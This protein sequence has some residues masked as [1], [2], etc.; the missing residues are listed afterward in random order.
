MKVRA[1]KAM[2]FAL[3]AV[4]GS[5]AG[6]AP[7]HDPHEVGEAE[8]SLLARALPKAQGTLTF[9]ARDGARRERRP[10]DDRLDENEALALRHPELD[11]KSHFLLRGKTLRFSFNQPLRGAKAGEPAARHIAVTPPITGVAVG[12]DDRTLELEAARYLDPKTKFSVTL[13]NIESVSGHKLAP[14]EATFRSTVGALI[15]GKE[16]GHVPVRGQPR[17]VAIVPGDATLG[18]RPTLRVLYDQPIAL[19]RARTLVRLEDEDDTSVPLA[20]AHAPENVFEGSR[21]DRHF[22]VVAVP[23]KALERGEDYVFSADDD[24]PDPQRHPNGF[25]VA[26]R[27]AL[28]G[29]ACGWSDDDARCQRDVA[30]RKVKTSEQEVHLVFNN[31]LRTPRHGLVPHVRVTPPV[32]NLA[33]SEVG[34]DEGRLQVT[35]DF[36]PSTRYRIS[37]SGLV[38]VF[39]QRQTDAVQVDL[40]IDALGASISMAEGLIMLDAARTRAFTI[41]SRN[42]A[43]A[44]LRLWKLKEGDVAAFKQG[45]AT[46]NGQNAKD[47]APDRKVRVAVVPRRDDIVTT[48]VD[49]RH[50]LGQGTSYL[51]T[52]VPTRFAFGAGPVGDGDGTTRPPVAL[53]RLAHDKSLRAHVHRSEGKTIV[54][55]AHLA[56]GMPVKDARVRLAK[57]SAK[58]ARKSDA[59]GIVTLPSD[60]VESDDMLVVEAPGDKLLLPLSQRHANAEALFPELARGESVSLNM[61]G[62]VVTD[63]G[64]YRPGSPVEIK[65][66]LFENQEGRLVP[67]AGRAVR[68]K[69]M[70]PTDHEV[71]G[72]SHKTSASGGVATRCA[73]PP[74]A[75]LGLY[76][77]EVESDDRTVASGVVRVA[78]FEAPRFKV[79]VEAGVAKQQLSSTV[80]AQ[81]LF[82]SPLEGA[83]VD[84]TLKRSPATLPAG[85]LAEL[86]LS[87]TSEP[88]WWDAEDDSDA[89]TQSGS[90]LL[91]AK[92]TVTLKQAVTMAGTRGPQRFTL[93]ADVSDSSYRHVANR[94]SVV[95]HTAKRYAG[96]RLP[97]SWVPLDQPIKVEL[98]VVDHDGKSVSGAATMAR[99]LAVD[100]REQRVRVA[101]GAVRSEWRRTEVEVARCT[102]TSGTRPV[103]C[104]LEPPRSGDYRVTAEVDGKV[105]GSSDVYAWDGED[106]THEARHPNRG[107]AIPLA[108][109][110]ASYAP[111]D[112]ARILVRNPYPAAIAILT[113]EQGELL[114]YESKRIDASAAVFEVPVTASHAPHLHASVTLLPIGAVD[115]EAV[116]YRIGALRLPVT[117]KGSR[118]DVAVTS[119]EP[120]YRPGAEADLELTVR[121]G[122]RPEA[123]AEVALAVVDEGV[124]RLT[125]FHALDPTSTLRPPLALDFEVSSSH[126]SLAE[127]LERSHVAGDGGG[128]EQS[129]TDARRRFVETAL[130]QPSVRTDAD[131]RARIRFRLPD[132]LTEFRIMAVAVDGEGKGGSAEGSFV[133]NKPLMIDPV[134]PRFAHRGDRLELAAMVHNQSASPFRG[135]VRIG[136]TTLPVSVEPGAR[137]RV[138]VETTLDEPGVR[139]LS[140]ALHDDGGKTV[141]AAERKLRVELPGIETRPQLAGAFAGEQVVSLELPRDMSF[142]PGAELELR[143]GQHLWPELGGRLEYL[144]QYPYGCVEQTTSSTLPL[145]AARDILPRIGADKYGE[146]FFRDRINAGLA[147]LNTMRTD[148]GGLAYWPGEDEPN[149]YGTAYAI[150]AVLAA[151][152]AGIEPPPG[153]LEGMTQFLEQHLMEATEQAIH[154]QPSI[155]QSLAEAGKLPPSSLDAL[156]DNRTSFDVFGK[157]SLA[158]ALGRLPRQED[159]VK[160]LL[161]EIEDAFDAKGELTGGQSDRFGYFSSD[162]RTSAQVAMALTRL[163]KSSRLLPLL[164]RQLAEEQDGYTTQATAY[165]LLAL[166]E[167]LTSDPGRGAEVTASLD[168]VPL[169]VKRDERAGS[170][171]VSIPLAELAGQKRKLTLA[172][173]RDVALG[174]RLSASYRLPLPAATAHDGPPTLTLATGDK[175]LALSAKDGPDIHRIIT[176]ASGDPLDLARVKAGDL[177]RVALLVRLPETRERSEYL[178]VSD[179]I[180]A[181]F[182]P[183]DP[184]LETVASAPNIA[185]SHPLA[186]RLSYSEESVSHIELHD[187]R[188]DIHFDQIHGREVTATYLLR[189]T[190]PGSFVVPPA[191]AELMYVPASTSITEAMKV[192][193]L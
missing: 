60:A 157:A 35:G 87:F 47:G 59:H 11:K 30:A 175:G 187:D 3:A 188:V 138:G 19:G 58:D 117:V 167:H 126:A 78:A 149:V 46:V 20:L 141:E 21:V 151:K 135:K 165:A 185:S 143:A 171:A 120:S 111:G 184:D 26:A 62:F 147:R 105:G 130:W 106:D 73:L 67:V 69:V 8:P 88:R 77:I 107:S 181:G 81:Y 158:L 156:F 4:L 139:N 84:W 170:V 70:G 125:G 95:V 45:L 127:L 131:G 91:D 98:G 33:V 52:L 89:W 65:T 43:E 74:T 168:G 140:F 162:D 123:N 5:C 128:E 129:L 34:W 150:R 57:Q 53:L 176:T 37:A 39:G 136:G 121:D 164:V 144:L 22:V 137:Q 174:F 99:L 92:G 56:S 54:Q 155:A 94:T 25:S 182:E 7:R 18:P 193:I 190:T 132:N 23:T 48:S 118:L 16:V 80:R 36:R 101:G 72:T 113:L 82:G 40:E 180:A 50:A 15:A 31:D 145:I 29:L 142:V 104:A 178:A 119:K 153:L 38:D 148:G 114:K 14:L 122:A 115:E 27:L 61:R 83:T 124:L 192:T 160:T 28:T 109:D 93:E 76:R 41:T 103:S 154:L 10:L 13:S 102:V 71:C 12:R 161:D 51:A 64:I 108:A 96:L 79:D 112:K 166:A 24:A 63:R 186:E 163:R 75:K 159:R 85:D 9:P 172:G 189:A 42:V 1:Q 134:V 86:G 2:T 6:G 183:V 177:V 191:S 133:V 66:S 68:V 110:K 173:P 169:T 55:V 32:R 97:S 44:E 116:G 146:K 179:R 17:V 90:S 100:W 49:L 152:H